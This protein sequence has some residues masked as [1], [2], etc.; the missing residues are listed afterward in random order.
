MTDRS[1]VLYRMTRYQVCL[2]INK[3]QHLE[4][5]VGDLE[6]FDTAA[7]L[8][9]LG[10]FYQKN[11]ARARMNKDIGNSLLSKLKAAEA[12]LPTAE[13]KKKGIFG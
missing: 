2:N 6:S 1:G 13:T 3:S 11:G 4:N 7:M 10:S 5:R 9:Q 8:S 12:S